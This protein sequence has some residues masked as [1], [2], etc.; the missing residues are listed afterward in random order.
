M[1]AIVAGIVAALC[2]AVAILGGA[3]IGRMLDPR[4]AGAWTVLA[5]LLI[6]TPL[7]LMEAAPTADDG[8]GL[9]WV[10]VASASL[11]VGV[12]LVFT[13][14]TVGKV[15]VAAPIISTEGAV[16][17][18]LAIVAGE[19]ASL[20]LILML[21]VVAVGIFITTL[22]PGTRMP[23]LD[24][25]DRYVLLA[26]GAALAY[27]VGLF[28]TSQAGET[29]SAGWIVGLTRLV[30]VLFITL[31]LLL[32]RR[33]T[34]TRAAIP[35]IVVASA[36]EIAGYYAFTVGT[37]ESTAVT[38]VL[39]SQFAVIAALVAYRM[40]ETISRRQ[41]GGVGIVAAG[42]ASVTLLSLS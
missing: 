5:S 19:P 17:A 4:S 10:A 26:I 27:G 16:A 11:I 23:R 42:V 41:W 40:G 1:L 18:S 33:L 7:F 29:I 20:P 32:T 30:A 9:S 38:A 24:G 39:A 36:A 2:W 14:L 37:R 28:A 15:P 31:P 13:A 12:L 6:A 34:L 8:V 35:V 25:D 21:G 3:R 22:E